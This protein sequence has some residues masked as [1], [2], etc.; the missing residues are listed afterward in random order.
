MIQLDDMLT[1]EEA[2]PWLKMSVK[3]L[4]AKSKGRKPIVPPF[5]MTAKTIRYCPRIVIAKLAADAGIG[6]ELIAAAMGKETKP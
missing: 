2:A 4:R 3:D 1:V 5:R 6:Q